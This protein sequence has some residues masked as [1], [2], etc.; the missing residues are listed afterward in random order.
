M[1]NYF[2]SHADK[3][4]IKNFFSDIIDCVFVFIKIQLMLLNISE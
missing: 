1:D 3:I 4:I 2:Y